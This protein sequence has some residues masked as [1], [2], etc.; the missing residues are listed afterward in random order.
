[1][2]VLG[3]AAVAL[4]TLVVAGL[5]ISSG[6]SARAPLPQLA[7]PVSSTHT[8]GVQG[9]GADVRAI[10]ATCAP[11]RVPLN[12]GFLV[13]SGRVT[14]L[15]SYAESPRLW[16]VVVDNDSPTVEATVRARAFCV[17]GFRFPPGLPGARSPGS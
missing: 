4:T 12:G 14:L 13:L 1:M 9:S 5:A 11:G 10:R 7:V 2:R 6:G 3:V 15:G 16:V 17:R 8:V